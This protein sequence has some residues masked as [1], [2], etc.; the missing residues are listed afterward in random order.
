M[1]LCSDWPFHSAALLW[2]AV[3]QC[4][5]ALIGRFTTR[6][7]SDWPFHSAAQLWLALLW[8]AV[9]QCGSALIGC[10]PV[11]LCSDW[12]CSDWPFHSAALLW[13]AVSQCD[14]ALIGSALIGHFTVRLCSDWLF[15][16]MAHRQ[17]EGNTVKIC[18]SIL[19]RTVISLGI[20]TVYKTQA[21]GSRGALK[22]LSNACFLLS[23]SRFVIK[24][25]SMVTTHYTRSDACQQCS[26]SVNHSPSP[27]V[28]SP[29]SVY[30]VS[31]ILC[32]VL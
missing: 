8:L 13:L 16:S 21:S 27:P 26:G 7:F 5:S 29:Y 22:L 28:I 31:E 3:S 6:L 1:R 9:S 2:L 23:L 20:Y 15:H 24:L 4:G 32:T 25:K 11:R 18:I 12:L 10:F 14:S 17:L 30:V 19:S